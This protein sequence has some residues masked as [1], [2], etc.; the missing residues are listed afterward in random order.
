MEILL[1]FV[2]TETSVKKFMGV[3]WCAHRR[4]YHTWTDVVNPT[5]RT[6]L[7]SLL[8]YDVTAAALSGRCRI[9]N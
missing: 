9:E 3:G 8:L 6:L 1:I 7:M 5:S 2:V 4:K